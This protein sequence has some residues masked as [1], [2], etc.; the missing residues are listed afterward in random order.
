MTQ[1]QITGGRPA[2]GDWKKKISVCS[3]RGHHIYK[4][5]FYRDKE[6][7]FMC[8]KILCTEPGCGYEVPPAR[9]ID[10]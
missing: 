10:K 7:G 8:S 5:K 9:V 4:T 2:K 1:L 3:R 6:S